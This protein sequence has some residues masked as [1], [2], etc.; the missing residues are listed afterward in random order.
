M[1]VVLKIKLEKLNVAQL[2]TELKCWLQ[3]ANG[4]KP[5][6]K[7]WLKKSLDEM[8]PWNSEKSIAKKKEL[9]K[10]KSDDN[11]RNK[12]STTATGLTGFPASTYWKELKEM[13]VTKEPPNPT[14]KKTQAPT[15]PE[16][17]VDVALNT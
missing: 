1:H 6:L 15:V 2:Q 17:G 4:N 7:E 3:S 11:K 16:A 10:W 9:E 14:F 12:K 8:K 5:I 13:I